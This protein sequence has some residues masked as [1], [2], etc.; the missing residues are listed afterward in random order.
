MDIF[1]IIRRC[2][3]NIYIIIRPQKSQEYIVTKYVN[4]FA[5]NARLN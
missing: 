4:I 1:K 3:R 5:F 2:F